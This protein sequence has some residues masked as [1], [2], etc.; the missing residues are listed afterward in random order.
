[1]PVEMELA[2]L[3]CGMAL[4]RR[5]RIHMRVASRMSWSVNTWGEETGVCMVSSCTDSLV[6]GK[7]QVK[8]PSCGSDLRRPDTPSCGSDF[9]RPPC[10]REKKSPCLGGAVAAV[11]LGMGC[12]ELCRSLKISRVPSDLTE[13]S[14]TCRDLTRFFWWRLDRSEHLTFWKVHF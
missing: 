9:R 5:R 3:E 14:N 8:S 4:W 13:I 10:L 6:C 2:G 12:V 1:M 11:H 7:R